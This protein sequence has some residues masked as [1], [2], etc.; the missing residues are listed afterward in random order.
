MVRLKFVDLPNRI[1]SCY[2]AA[3]VKS[4][5]ADRPPKAER[6]PSEFYVYRNDGFTD[7]WRWPSSELAGGWEKAESIRWLP[8]AAMQKRIVDFFFRTWDV[9]G[10]DIQ[11]SLRAQDD[12]WARKVLS[13]G[14]LTPKEAYS[15]IVDHVDRYHGDD[16]AFTAW[17]DWHNADHEGS[18][19][20]VGP[21]L[22]GVGF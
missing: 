20:A 5:G 8:D 17:E 16:E 2:L 13:R 7:I 15:I 4:A 18:T 3:S 10:G 21:R 14:T 12:K 9:I 6:P 22:K 19:K 1:Q 11:D